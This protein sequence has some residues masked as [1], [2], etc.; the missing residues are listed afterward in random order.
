MKSATASEGLKSQLAALQRRETSSCIWEPAATPQATPR[1][2]AI[3]IEAELVELLH[4][5]IESHETHRA[6]YDR[7]ERELYALLDRLTDIE[8]HALRQRLQVARPNDALVQAFV[9][10]SI[11][12]RP[13][14]FAF[15]ENTRRRNSMRR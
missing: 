14:V 9:R 7:K 12:R 11:E 8:A 6:G 3:G 4:Q 13:R 1:P 10:L 15:I 5:P 2:A